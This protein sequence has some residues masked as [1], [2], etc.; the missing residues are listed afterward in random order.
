[1]CQRRLESLLREQ[2]G[3]HTSGPA[4]AIGDNHTPTSHRRGAP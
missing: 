1:V 2:P 4:V 3:Q